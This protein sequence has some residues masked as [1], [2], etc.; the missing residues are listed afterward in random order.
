LL[1]TGT[2]ASPLDCER[3]H[4]TLP[5]EHFAAG[6]ST[7]SRA[8]VYPLSDAKPRLRYFRGLDLVAVEPGLASTLRVSGTD[9]SRI[10]SPSASED[11]TSTR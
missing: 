6:Q 9:P 11:A 4:H 5:P 7:N 1:A 3:E 8:R 10:W 2:G